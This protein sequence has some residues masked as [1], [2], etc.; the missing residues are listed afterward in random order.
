MVCTAAGGKLVFSV[1][2]IAALGAPAFFSTSGPTVLRRPWTQPASRTPLAGPSRCAAKRRTPPAADA[3]A[4]RA[5]PVRCSYSRAVP[6]HGASG[7]YRFRRG[8]RRPPPGTRRR[9]GI[10]MHASP[11]P[12]RRIVRCKIIRPLH[13]G[14]AD[15]R[16][17]HAAPALLRNTKRGDRC[18]LAAELPAG[19]AEFP[20]NALGSIGAAGGRHRGGIA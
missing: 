12:C 18:S 10:A 5:R 1:I 8:L 7:K 2:T 6:T 3:A 19:R 9:R 17:C 14:R 20:I 11:S 4:S 13:G 16:L 15:I